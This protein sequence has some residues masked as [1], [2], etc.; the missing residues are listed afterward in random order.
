MAKID[1]CRIMCP[2]WYT[3][4]ASMIFPTT[5]RCKN[6]IGKKGRVPSHCY[7]CLTEGSNSV[8]AL[9][10]RLKKQGAVVKTLF[11]TSK[12]DV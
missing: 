1:T 6:P 9:R 3:C 2:G 10:L 4:I 5:S 8:F 12:G 11:S 7:V